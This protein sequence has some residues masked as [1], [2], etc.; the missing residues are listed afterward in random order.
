M[1]LQIDA[2]GV[3]IDTYQE[4]YTRVADGFRAIY[5]ADID[6]DPE[7]PDGQRVGIFAS[8]IHDLQSYGLAVSQFVDPDLADGVWLEKALKFAAI[9]LR[10]PNRSQVDVEITTDRTLNLQEGYTVDDELGNSW[11]LQSDQTVQPGTST[12]TLFAEEFGEIEAPADTVNDPSTVVIGVT[13]VTNPNPA[14]P[15]RDEE[16]PAEARRRRRRSVQAPAYSMAGA[17]FARLADLI[18]VTD[19]QVYEND[20]DSADSRGIPA[21]GIWAVIE[22]GDIAD[23]T[24]VIVRNKTGGTPLKGD[25]SSTYTETRTRPD[26]SEFDITYDIFFDR[27]TSTNVEVRLDVTRKDPNEPI[28]TGAIQESLSGVEFRIA[29][30]IISTELYEPVYSG[31]GNFIAT[32]LEIRRE[33]DSTWIAGRLEADPDERFEIAEGDVTVTEV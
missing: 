21:H 15:G 23:I 26:G 5:G 17:L 16:T 32:N 12:I 24:E 1:T 7:S 2:N 11:V 6:L 9:T 25:I 3:Q 33:G 29:E 8:I 27:P 14:I 22:G 18:G 13:G 19:V 4:V 20:M 10:P 31:E 30:N 28:D